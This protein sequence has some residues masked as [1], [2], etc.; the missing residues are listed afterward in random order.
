MDNDN[1]VIFKGNKD[2]L[3]IILDENVD[4]VQIKDILTMK[5]SE[6]KK[7][8]SKANVSLKFKGRILTD[9]ELDELIEIIKNESDLII[10]FIKTEPMI[11]FLENEPRIRNK[12][13]DN[14]LVT[15]YHK[16]S[17]RSGQSLKY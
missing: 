12:I 17:I 11:Q 1:T 15:V 3:T 6:G 10:T 13:S 8:F 5:L 9:E 14:S 4:F 7:F 2:G 16:G